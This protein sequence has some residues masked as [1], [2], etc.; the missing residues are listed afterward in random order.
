VKLISSSQ[1]PDFKRLLALLQGKSRLRKDVFWVEGPRQ[2]LALSRSRFEPE[3]VFLDNSRSMDGTVKEA[4]QA[5][6]PHVPVTLL[7][8]HLFGRLAFREKP[9][10]ILV[11][12]RK[13][14]CPLSA[15]RPGKGLV[16]VADRWEKPGNLGALMRS[17]NAF[18]VE[19]MILSGNTADPFLPQVQRNAAG[20]FF[21]TPFFTAS[22]ET[23]ADTLSKNGYFILAADAGGEVWRPSMQSWEKPIA[24]IIGS[25][26][27]GVSSF[28]RNRADL[29]L[30]LPM[31]GTVDSLN[32][33]VAAAVM[34]FLYQCL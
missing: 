19:A 4:L 34:I 28:W 15:W 30:A 17:A 27:Q 23:I 18:G 25:E 24:L 33:S 8:E 32:A 12:A 7:E 3:E 11:I 22:E 6:P 5:I 2:V 26:H 20:A 1:N 9:E 10:G 13:E 16:V 21:H 29:I 31:Q 14:N